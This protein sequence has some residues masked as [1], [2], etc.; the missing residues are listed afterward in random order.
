MNNKKQCLFKHIFLI[1]IIRKY[2]HIKL[3]LLKIYPFLIPLQDYL[4]ELNILILGML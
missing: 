4:R 2:N 3:L 1:K